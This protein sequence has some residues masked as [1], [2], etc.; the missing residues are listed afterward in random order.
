MPQQASRSALSSTFC[1]EGK[2]FSICTTPVEG[3]QE[4]EVWV[5]VSPNAKE[6]PCQDS[7]LSAGQA[8][9][10]QVREPKLPHQGISSGA[11]EWPQHEL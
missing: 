10:P 8:P 2:S 3:V 7:A 5:A 1:R 11:V 4:G 6:T 9:R